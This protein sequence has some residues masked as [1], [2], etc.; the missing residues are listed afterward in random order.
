MNF[1][2]IPLLIYRISLGKFY[3]EHDG[4]DYL[5]Y[6]P[7]I[8][9]KY[10]SELLYDSIITDNKYEDWI[11]K[12]NLDNILSRLGI[13][14]K[15]HENMLK[16]LESKIEN[17]KADLY[18]NRLNKDKQK[19]LRKDLE[20]FKK[21]LNNLYAKKHSM[22]YLTL[23]DHASIKKSEYI[24]LN[25]LYY[26]NSNKRVF[27][28]DTSKINFE[29]FNDLLSI[30]SLYFI[31]IQTYKKISRHEM[32]KSIFNTNKENPFNKNGCEL[33][34]EQ[35]TLMSV[36]IMYDRIYENPECPEEY[37]IE[38]DDMLDGWMLIQKKK[39]EQSK[40]QSAASDILN[41]HGNAR[42]IFITGNKEDISTILD[43]NS[44][45]SKNIINQRVKLISK[46]QDGID[47]S[48]LPDVQLDMLQHKNVN[49][50]RK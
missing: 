10:E 34:D 16:H 35:R 21:T 38:D 46:S 20:N 3:F 24:V 17:A 39:N 43:L 22:D 14:N 40:K 15:D 1:D 13:W 28:N 41:K 23:E 27:D 18:L 2:N 4:E 47:E 45:E 49:T 5:L 6:S 29:Y 11:R 33:T 7:S 36:S 31:D 48:S 32:W 37:V 26:K 12:E 25:T 9:L 44:P 50:K 30:I 42:E 8:E 19:T